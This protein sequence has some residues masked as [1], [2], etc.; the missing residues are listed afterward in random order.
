MKL[1]VCIKIA[2]ENVTY[3]DLHGCNSLVLM[4][5]FILV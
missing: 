1:I 5:V 3:T 2:L 4:T